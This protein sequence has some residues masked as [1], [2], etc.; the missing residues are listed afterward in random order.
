MIQT[1]ALG[2]GERVKNDVDDLCDTRDTLDVGAGER[3]H[4]W[5]IHSGAAG[6]RKRSRSALAYQGITYT[7]R[8]RVVDLGPI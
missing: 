7:T 3:L 4:D 8:E 1:G 6:Y 2:G 5:R